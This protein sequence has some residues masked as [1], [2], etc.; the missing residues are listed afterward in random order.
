MHQE[1]PP[2]YER[3]RERAKEGKPY[4]LVCVLEHVWQTSLG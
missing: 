2:D 4:Q 3:E 1:I